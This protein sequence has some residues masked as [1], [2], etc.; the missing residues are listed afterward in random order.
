MTK[1]K[2]APRRRGV[3]VRVRLDSVRGRF[4]CLGCGGTATIRLPARPLD[5]ILGLERFWRAHAEC[6]PAAAGAPK[7]RLD[8][9][10]RKA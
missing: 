2:A 1:R 6:S 3:P 10:R 8:R 4:V 5:Y 9:A 7:K